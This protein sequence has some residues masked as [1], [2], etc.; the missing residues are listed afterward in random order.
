MQ[1]REFIDDG[2]HILQITGEVDMAR[3]PE[4]RTVLAA[5][6]F[7]VRD[8]SELSIAGIQNKLLVNALPEGR[9]GRPRN[10]QPST[11]IMKLADGRDAGLLAAEHACMELAAAVGL[12]TVQTNLLSFDGIE[13]LAVE[14]YDRVTDPSSGVMTRL[15]QEDACQALG[16]NI[17]A[18]QGTGKYQ[19]SGG[20]SFE[21][22]AQLLDRHGD[23]TAEHRTLLR[24]VVFTFIIGNADAHGKN[25]SILIDNTT[26]AITLAPL[27][28]TVP[29]ALWP[30]LR[31]ASAMSV[32][33]Q[34]EPRSIRLHDF[35]AE[36]RRWGMGEARAEQVVGE[37]LED[38]RRAVTTCTHEAV[39][40]L[41]L[42][43]LHDV[44]ASDA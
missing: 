7:A 24:T 25:L 10:G 34:F 39:A 41:V 32:N 35:I 28:D 13:V 3:S 14:R 44:K 2:L 11:H 26:G 38:I 27:Y 15:H 17:E 1:V 5:P 20:P 22:I 36:A 4:L 12:T 43:R 40:A 16:T 21:Q 30:R 6:G 19:R 31:S 37:V 8:D 33:G 23:P 18:N 42:T 29:T 9:W